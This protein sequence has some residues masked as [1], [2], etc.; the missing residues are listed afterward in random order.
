MSVFGEISEESRPVGAGVGGGGS[1]A[2]RA[3]LQILLADDTVNQQ[4]ALALLEKM[5]T[6]RTSSPTARRFSRRSPASGMTSC[7]WMWRCR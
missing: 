5:A 6:A 3:P 7:L 4:V 2:E 1:S